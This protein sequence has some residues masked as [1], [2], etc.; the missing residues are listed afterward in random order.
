MSKQISLRIRGVGWLPFVIVLAGV[1]GCGSAVKVEGKVTYRGRPV[2]CGSV[3]VVCA[4]RTARSGIIGPDGS[5]SVKGLPPGTVKMG[6]VSRDPSSGRSVVRDGK[7]VRPEKVE[8]WFA[9]P[10][11]YE[12]PEG[13]GLGCTV[14]S[15][16][17][18]Y[19]IDLK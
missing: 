3:I 4:D 15:G 6:V 5:Y 16:R 8:G 13:S 17:V 18:T 11:K 19:D 12:A 10:Q 7:R 1:S 14:D 2:R 9:L